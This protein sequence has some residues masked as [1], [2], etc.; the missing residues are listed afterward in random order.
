MGFLGKPAKKTSTSLKIAAAIIVLIIVAVGVFAAWTYPRTVL[1]FPVSFTVGAQSVRKGFSIPMLDSWVQV[2][3]SV[4]SG[5]AL[6]GAR[7][8]GG[9]DTEIWS[10]GAV[11]GGQTTYNSGWMQLPSGNYNFTFGTFG[12]GTL[13]AEITV[14]SEGGFW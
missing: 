9:N 6:W 4:S 8:L 3:V 2:Q 7:I 5:A 11:Q 14:S 10:H 13:N 12:I 1:G